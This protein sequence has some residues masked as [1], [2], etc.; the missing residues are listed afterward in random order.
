MVGKGKFTYQ[1]NADEIVLPA[2]TQAELAPCLTDFSL[3]ARSMDFNVSW[4]KTKVQCLGRA[5]VQGQV[6]EWVAHFC[7]LGSV[8]DSNEKSGPDILRRLG[9]GGSN[10]IHERTFQGVVT[11]KVVS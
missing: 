4:T 8:Q 7:Y 5:V 11:E 3:S 1:D 10:L 9:L 6:V 2:N